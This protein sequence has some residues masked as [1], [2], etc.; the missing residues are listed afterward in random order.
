LNEK[1]KSSENWRRKTTDLQRKRT[2]FVNAM[3]AGSPKIGCF[4]FY[5]DE[6][7]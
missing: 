2:E 6:N 3:M 5:L 1:G 4:L 7:E